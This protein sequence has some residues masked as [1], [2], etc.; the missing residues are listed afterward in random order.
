MII[1][2]ANYSNSRS[3]IIAISPNSID[4]YYLKEDISINKNNEHF[5]YCKNRDMALKLLELIDIAQ[6]HSILELKSKYPEM[7]I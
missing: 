1:D 2:L 7:L 4:T 3:D 6:S 5:V